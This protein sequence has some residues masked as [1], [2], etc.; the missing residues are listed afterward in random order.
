MRS[1]PGA[2]LALGVSYTKQHDSS[3]TVCQAGGVMW[4][5]V[6]EGGEA[7]LEEGKEGEVR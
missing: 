7:A 1:T 5:C 3:L 6:K 2:A 4:V